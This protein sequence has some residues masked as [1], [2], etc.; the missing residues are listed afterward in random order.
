[1][2][3]TKTLKVPYSYITI[4]LHNHYVILSCNV[5]VSIIVTNNAEVEMIH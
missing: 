2:I 1:M 3:T 5:I 4:T